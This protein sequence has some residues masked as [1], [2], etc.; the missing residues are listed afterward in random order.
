MTRDEVVGLLSSYFP[1]IGEWEPFADRRFVETLTRRLEDPSPITR[2]HLN[3]F[4]HLANQAGM[5]DGF[6]RYYFLSCPPTHPYALDLLFEATPALDS[7]G[8]SS[9]EQLRWGL[10][11]FFVDGLFFF[12]NLRT[13]YRELRNLSCE[14]LEAYFANFRFDTEAMQRRGPALSFRTIPVDDRYLIAE[15]ACKA[16]SAPTAGE[17]VALEQTLLE[18]YRERGGGSVRIGEL[19][20]KGT[21]IATRDPQAQFMLEFGTDEFVEDMVSSE[22]EIREKVQR[23]L[24]RFLKARGE[25]IENTRLYLSVVNELDVYVATSM[26]TRDHFRAMNRDCQRIFSNARLE[27]FQLRYFDPTIS[28]A[29]GHED[30]G[31]IE[32]LMV[33]CSKA[34]VY[35]AGE[36]DSFGKDAEVAMALSLGRPVIILCPDST[37]G[38]QRRRFFQEVHPLSKLIHMETGIAVGAMITKDPEVV[39]ELLGRIFENRMVYDV[40]HHGDAYYRL[41][42]RLTGSV[43]RLQTNCDILQESFWNYYHG[44]E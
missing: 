29:D 2:T 24:P 42:E 22:D 32:C 13:A 28:A 27:H 1:K 25:A 12:G 44:V 7:D 43:V 16:Y 31:L 23:I 20:S 19:F 37:E 36:R 30:K 41:K 33:K 11:R 8:I 15:V 21:A 34:L 17:P 14:T 3:Q 10:H 9:L 5:S 35:F 38:E 18:A 39:V 26:R 6:F 4:L 40:D